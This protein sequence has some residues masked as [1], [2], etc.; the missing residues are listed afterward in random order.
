MAAW[1]VSPPRE[2]STPIGGGDAL[3]IVRAGLRPD[4]DDLLALLSQPQ[5]FGGVEDHLA[6]GRPG[7]R[8]QAVRQRFVLV[9]RLNALVQ[10]GLQLLRLH[11][12]H[13]VFPRDQAF[14]GHLDGY[15]HGRLAAPLAGPGLQDIQ[16]TGLD[17]E[18]HVL[19]VVEVPLQLARH[20]F[21]LGI[22]VGHR[23]AQLLN[24]RRSPDPGDQVLA[25][26]PADILPEKLRVSRAG[27]AGEHHP[28]PRPVIGVAHD[29][30]LHHGRGAYV[31]G[32]VVQAPVLHRPEVV[33]G[34][35][36]LL[37]G[38]DHVLLAPDIEQ[39]VH[40]PRHGDRG[41]GANGH[42]QPVTHP[43]PGRL[44]QPVEALLDIIDGQAPG[45]PVLGIGLYRDHETGGHPQADPGHGDQVGP[46]V[47]QEHLVFAIIRE[48][49]NRSHSTTSSGKSST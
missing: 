2:V 32:N 22:D 27:V 15:P 16:G 25:L 36:D 11:P 4:Q 13:R 48:T 37:D 42:H 6:E 10:Q 19:H 33:P 3:D 24:G 46:F 21:Q 35:E 47:A 40:H 7:G 23:L 5:R 18:L 8:I 41:R 1:E 31:A 39:R 26:R 43:L 20:A 9:R 45:A 29:H 28:G 34:A 30:R 17:G 44:F 14:L 38:R 12:L 49:V